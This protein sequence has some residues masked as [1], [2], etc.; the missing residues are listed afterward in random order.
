MTKYRFLDPMG[1]SPAAVVDANPGTGQIACPATSARRRSNPTQQS[2]PPAASPEP[3]G[4]AAGRLTVVGIGA[5]GWDGLSPAARQ[6]ATAAEVL[7]GSTRQLGLLPAAVRGRRV[8][9]PSPL[10]PALPGLLAEHQGRPVC[11]LASGDPMCHGLGS[12]LARLV[13]PAAIRV[14]PHVSSVSLACARL[15]WPAEEV[16]VVSVVGRP[17]ELLHPVVAPGAR[18][19][20]LSADGASPAQVCALLAGRGYGGSEVT[21]LERLG[22]PEEGVRTGPAAGWPH[23]E[24]DPLNVVAVHCHA[25]PDAALL[26]RTPGLPDEAYQHDGQ[27]TKREIRAVTLAVLAPVPGQLLWDVGA[28]AGSIAIEWMRIH[29]AC[30]AVAV[31]SRADRAGTIGRNAAALGVPGLRV[32]HG[33]A[34]AALTGLDRPDAAFV[35]GGGTVPGVLPACWDALL[36]GGRLVVNAVTLEAEALVASW[37]RRHG[38]ELRRLAVNRASPV[39]GLTAWRPMMPVTQWA[40]TKP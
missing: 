16:E 9:W 30:R 33:S 34:P 25:D 37:Q 12:T 40:V 31:E 39:G 8:A 10:L 22:G 6:A 28:G 21:V 26:P 36:P 4:T 18:L 23:Q 17:V 24:A 19:L 20:V 29:P 3:A 15:G 5:D 14:V 27:L 11:L 1:D 38:G 7:M 35:G 13:G 32:V 2:S